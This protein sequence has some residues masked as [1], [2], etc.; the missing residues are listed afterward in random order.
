MRISFSGAAC[1]GK[2]TIIQSFLHKW[3][4]YTLIDSKYRKLIK[5]NTRHSKETTPKLQKEILNLLVEESKPYTAHNR[6]V[7]DR[8]SLDN[9]VYTLWAHGKEKKGFT[10]SFVKETIETVKESMRNLDIIFICTRDFMPAVIQQNGI[11]ET[12]P[13]F[14]EETNNIFKEIS[15]QA[16]T[17][18]EGSPF[19]P[20]GDSPGIINLYGNVEERLAQISLYVTE[21]G[22]SFGEE[23]SFVSMDEINKM[24]SL[25]VDQ[26]ESLSEEQKLKLGILDLNK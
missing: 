19:F 1:T 12:D 25:L 11:R 2:T 26:K 18:V 24:Y 21:E 17:D 10:D 5:K 15:K 4:N 20:K 22:N 3:P 16:Q 9:L 14:V 7:Y 13:V 6:V 23:Q 8:C